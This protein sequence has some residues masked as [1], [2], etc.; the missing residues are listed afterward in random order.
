MTSFGGWGIS[1]KMPAESAKAFEHLAR[2]FGGV[3]TQNPAVRLQKSDL[4][5]WGGHAEEAPWADSPS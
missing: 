3:P 4:A 1:K 2:P 5:M